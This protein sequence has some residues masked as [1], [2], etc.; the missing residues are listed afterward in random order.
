MPDTTMPCSSGSAT[1]VLVTRPASEA[2]RWVAQLRAR[3][4]DAL[5]LPLID[6][7]CMEDLRPIRAAWHRLADYAAVMFVS[8]NAV[9]HFFEQKEAVPSVKW[10]PSAI[11]TRA[12]S[13]G[14]GT[15]AAVQQA[16]LDPTQIDAPADDATQ[17]DSEALWA[18]VGAQVRSG[19]R[20]LIVRGGDASGQGN[21]RD[22]LADQLA[23]AGVRVDRLI[24]YRRLAPVLSG[25]QRELVQRAASDASVW[26]FS[27][28]EAVA[29][30]GREFPAQDWRHA[31]AVATHPR[32]A[33]TVR[34]TGF[35]VVCE[36]RPTLDAVVSSIKSIE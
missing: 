16:G 8:A 31:R 5:A 36:S 2:Q 15:S 22:W 32:I 6:I 14:P 13:T 7:G 24:A 27:S 9:V 4:F 12:W 23:G 1:R 25:D 26:V 28:S 11:K 18:R 19:Q 29:H 21:G 30:L 3:G 35:G 34:R 10:H 20:V 17:F 33:E